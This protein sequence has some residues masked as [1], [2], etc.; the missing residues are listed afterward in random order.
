MKKFY[1]NKSQMKSKPT[2]KAITPQIVLK[3]YDVLFSLNHLKLLLD[4]PNFYIDVPAY[5]NKFFFK[6][7]NDIF[8][9]NGQTFELLSRSDAKNR[10]PKNYKK[11][12]VYETETNQ[13][14]KKKIKTI[15]LCDYFDMDLFLKTNDTKLTIDY[16]KDY[17]FKNTHFI[18]G[19]E[20]EYNYLNMKKDL[21]RDYKKVLKPNTETNDG[22]KL[23]FNHIKSIICSDDED[24]YNTT[25]KFLA[26]SCAG[27]KVK[28]AL[29]WQ[30]LEQS[31]KGSVLNYM[32]DLLGMRMYKTSSVESVEKYT[33][34][35]EG[36][37]LINLDEL[38]IAGTSKTLQDALK[39]LITEPSFDC[40]EMY[41]EGYTQLN[42][43]NIIITSNNNCI[44]LTQSNNIRYYVNTISDKYAGNKNTEYFVNLHK[45]INNDNVKVAIFQEFMRIYETEVKPVN[46][47]GTSVK[48]TKAGIVKRIEALPHF[49]KYIKTSYLFN[50]IGIDECSSNFI[51]EYQLNNQRD[52]ISVTN[53]GKYLTNL[54]VELRKI[55]NKD[56]K[57]RKYIISFEDLKNAF[58]KNNWLLDDEI[59]DLEKFN[60]VIEDNEEEI[61]NPLDIL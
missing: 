6:Y 4:S 53:I 29:V 30:S 43:F 49:I 26:S 44:S 14:T 50:G 57:G 18:R 42:T 60:D 25:I 28:I 34:N 38:P 36:R 27:H 51:A 55:N 10:I 40:R 58:L 32:N 13:E 8:F 20:V 12:V 9:D 54:N 22:V 59:E 31:G 37:T 24:E 41:N 21:P 17:K 7:G 48:P 1:F 2:E 16:D 23:F 56:F 35:F 46:W 15:P 52:K 5:M 19:F 3:K 45:V 33:K 11:S 47:I 39:A 61:I